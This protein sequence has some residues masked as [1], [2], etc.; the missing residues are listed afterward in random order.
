ML[1]AA[2]DFEMLFL[3]E[4]TMQLSDSIYRNVRAWLI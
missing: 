1:P 2:L 3:T 4:K